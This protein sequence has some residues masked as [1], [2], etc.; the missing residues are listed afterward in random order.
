MEIGSV[1]R[2]KLKELSYQRTFNLGNY[3]SE[4]IQLVVEVD[5]LQDLKEQYRA[6]KQQVFELHNTPKDEQTEKARDQIGKEILG[7]DSP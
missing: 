6:L 1:E 3:E 5:E 2:V 4:R 7:E